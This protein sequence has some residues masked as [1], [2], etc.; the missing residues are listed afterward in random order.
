M[1]ERFYF[2]S[3]GAPS[4]ISCL[5]ESIR[6]VIFRDKDGECAVKK[7]LFHA[8]RQAMPNK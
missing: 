1:V 2:K 6:Y 4:E 7:E 3:Y 8:K 5:A